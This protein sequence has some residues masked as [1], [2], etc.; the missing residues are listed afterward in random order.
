MGPILRQAVRYTPCPDL[1]CITA[2]FNSMHYCTR[3]ANY[4]T[5]AA[6]LRAAGIPLLTVECAF[7]DDAFELA[8]GPD[9]FQVRGRDVL[10]QKERLINL[11]MNRLPPEATK[12]AWLDCDI[13]FAN[14][15]WA[16]QTAA[17][18]DEV[19]VVQPF[20]R[21]GRLERGRTTFAGAARCSF[22]CQQQ[23]RPE[24]AQLRGSA[25]GHPGIAWAARRSLLERHGIYDAATSGG[26]DELFAHAAGGGLNSRCVRAIA[27]ARLR[28]LPKIA[29]KFINRLLSIPWPRWLA[30]WYLARPR[31]MPVPAP[32][33]RFFAHYLRWARPFA[34]DV[35]GQIGYVPG[36][37]LHLWHGSP[38]NRQYGSRN[39]IFKRYDFDPTSDLRLNAQGLWEWASAKPALHQ[40]VRDYFH[41]RREDG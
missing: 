24:S 5:F 3:R 11:G 10:W 1:W 28:S 6:P 13:L 22:A 36:L 31:I 4:E 39:A 17:R 40:V 12:V 26:G 8:P 32:G 2:Y 16:V 37:A 14:P 18:L 15:D 27:G 20:D 21:V 7:G 19:A 35:R 30:T 38:V 29:N 25:H 34:T 41:A 23:R 9:V 33:E